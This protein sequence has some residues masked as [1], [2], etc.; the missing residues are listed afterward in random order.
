MDFLFTLL[1]TAWYP[2]IGIYTARTILRE[3]TTPGAWDWL[4]AAAMVPLWPAVEVVP[5]SAIWLRTCAARLSRTIGR[6]R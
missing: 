2:A 1:L 6:T 3:D 4:Y 5:P